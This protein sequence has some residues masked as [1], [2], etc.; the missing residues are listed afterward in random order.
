[1]RKDYKITRDILIELIS[2]IPEED[3]EDILKQA[4]AKRKIKVVNPSKFDSLI[5]LFKLGGDALKDTETYYNCVANEAEEMGIKYIVSF[6]KD[7]DTMKELTRIYDKQSLESLVHDEPNK[8][9]Q[10]NR[11]DRP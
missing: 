5:G 2:N 4:R 6:D 8:P 3:L 9:N 11:P 1:M 10:P 7:F